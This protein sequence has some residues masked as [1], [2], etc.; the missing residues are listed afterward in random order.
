MPRFRRQKTYHLRFSDAAAGFESK[1]CDDWRSSMI[2]HIWAV[3][4]LVPL[5]PSGRL[6]CMGSSCPASIYLLLS[7]FIIFYYRSNHN[8]QCLKVL[9]M[10]PNHQVH[11]KLMIYSCGFLLNSLSFLLLQY[12]FVPH[13]L[14]KHHLTL[15]AELNSVYAHRFSCWHW[16]LHE[17]SISSSIHSLSLIYYDAMWAKNSSMW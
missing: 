15:D 2:F 6:S 13:L 9:F 16:I 3:G 7:L 10:L 5:A 1:R 12:L 4:P 14:W 11:S 17:N 8:P